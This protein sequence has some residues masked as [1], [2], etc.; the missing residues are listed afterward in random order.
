[1]EKGK[2]KVEDFEVL[3]TLGTGRESLMQ[4]HSAGC[5]WLATSKQAYA[6]P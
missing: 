3:T 2:L 4:E 1:M 5:A 6:T